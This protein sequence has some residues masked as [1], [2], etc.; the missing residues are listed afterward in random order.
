MNKKEFFKQVS[1]M[2]KYKKND[3]HYMI[4]DII[5][6]LKDD[7]KT[8][9]ILMKVYKYFLPTISKMD[10]F[11]TAPVKTVKQS[12]YEY[13]KYIRVKGGVMMST[14]VKRLHKKKKTT[15]PDGFYDKNFHLLY[16]L[17]D[18]YTPSFPNVED[19]FIQC[20]GYSKVKNMTVSEFQSLFVIENKDEMTITLGDIEMY[21]NSKYI[22]DALSGLK[23]N[24]KLEIRYN[25]DE[26]PIYITVNNREALIMPMRRHY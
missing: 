24:D 21:F 22:F 13:D 23:P 4:D 26:S 18:D 7:D 19:L 11:I 17:D 20:Q 1:V 16:D 5:Q 6:E 10:K 8:T 14:D 2:K 12:E 15:L 3:I 9:E 25:T